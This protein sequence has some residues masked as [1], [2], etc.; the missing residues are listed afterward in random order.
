MGLVPGQGTD[1]PHTKGQGQKKIIIHVLWEIKDSIGPVKQE[2]N[3]IVRRT[4]EFSQKVGLKNK[5]MDNTKAKE[6]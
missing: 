3:I 6:M 4:I 2:H 5:M 1:T